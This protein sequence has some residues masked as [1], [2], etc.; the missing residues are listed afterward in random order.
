MQCLVWYPKPSNVFIARTSNNMLF[1]IQIKYLETPVWEN[2]IISGLFCLFVF[3]VVVVI[4]F[5]FNEL[6]GKPQH[7]QLS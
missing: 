6:F 2:V 4:F 7:T 3:T 1:P 5:F